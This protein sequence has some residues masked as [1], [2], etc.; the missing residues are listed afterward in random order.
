MKLTVLYQDESIIAIHKP[1][2][3]L[4]H[5]NE[6]AP[7][8][9]TVLQSL[10]DQIGQ[11][12]YPVHRPCSGLLLLALNSKTASALGAQL[13]ERKIIKSYLAWVRGWP[14]DEGEI[15]RPLRGRPA[16]TRFKTQLRVEL[17]EP[18]GRHPS[19]RY[20]LL[21]LWPKSGRRHQL[22]R[23]LAGLAYPILGDTSHG[24]GRH[25]RFFRGRF[26]LNRLML[27]ALELSFE[28]PQSGEI[29]N[30]EAP[31]DGVWRRVRAE[32]QPW[33]Q[34]LLEEI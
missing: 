11:R 19:A 32:C 4:V 10:R 12:L 26:G 3:L 5:R 29:L 18:V 21:K 9:A 1:S 33:I 6:H 14:P 7:H 22:R 23:H 16:S 13:R 8:A 27:H 31:V 25:N 15:Q 2:G 20:A 24:D 28:Q 34:D 30:L 17:P